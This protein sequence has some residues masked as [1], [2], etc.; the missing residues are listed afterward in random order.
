[1]LL[2]N[3]RKP[4]EYDCAV[5]DGGTGIFCAHRV[6]VGQ[7]A[8]HLECLRIETRGTADGKIKSAS[9]QKFNGAENYL[10]RFH[11][12]TYVCVCV[13]SVYID[14]RDDSRYCVTRDIIS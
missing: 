1:M 4:F 9:R 7:R 11:V 6:V 8:R 12:R 13:R 10:F 5:A 2:A 3:E 14:T